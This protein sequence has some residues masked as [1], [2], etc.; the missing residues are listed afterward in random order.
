MRVLFYE[1]IDSTQKKAIELILDRNENLSESVLIYTNNQTSGVGRSGKSWKFVDGNLAMSLIVGVSEYHRPYS[2]IIGCILHQY[3]R[4][5]Y[6]IFT[7]LKWPNDI[8]LNGKKAGG[9]ITNI[10]NRAGKLYLIIGI[11]LNLIGS[12]DNVEYKT[13]DILY[14][15]GISID[16]SDIAVLLSEEIEKLINLTDISTDIDSFTYAIGKKCE[17]SNQQGVFLCISING[18]AVVEV[19]GKNELFVSSTLRFN[20]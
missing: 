11:G 19:N 1:N 20:E 8:M 7:E 12:V 4:K 9:V 18:E 13:T 10:E 14:E 17:I 6:G 5:K 2:V 16:N 15:T 3:L